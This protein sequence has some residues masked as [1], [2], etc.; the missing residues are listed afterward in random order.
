MTSLNIKYSPIRVKSIQSCYYTISQTKRAY[1][2]PISDKDV[3]LFIFQAYFL[4][5]KFF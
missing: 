3:R 5:I 4:P 1:E 2:L